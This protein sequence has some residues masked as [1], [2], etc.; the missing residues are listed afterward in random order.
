MLLVRSL[1]LLFALSIGCA[2]LAADPP[3]KAVPRPEVQFVS[4]YI[5]ALSETESIR[6]DEEAHL[7]STINSKEHYASCVHFS[8][9]QM[10][11]MGSAADLTVAYRLGGEASETPALLVRYYTTRRGLFGSLRNLCQ[12]PLQGSKLDTPK[13]E[14]AI[15]KV[16]ADIEDL[17]KSLLQMSVIVFDALTT[18]APDKAGNTSRL[19]VTKGE[20]DQLVHQISVGFKRLDAK[21]ANYTVSAAALLWEYLVRRGYRCVDEPA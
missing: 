10:R 4:Q 21:D 12:A 20:R 7:T 18:R 17:D 2:P 19:I 9:L 11:A 6:A 16:R 8:Q 14:A 13:I 15:S 3:G 5:R 1:A